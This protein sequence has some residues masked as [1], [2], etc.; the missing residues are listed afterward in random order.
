VPVL[1][2]KRAMAAAIGSRR[3]RSQFSG[4]QWPARDACDK[5]VWSGLWAVS[6]SVLRIKMPR[7]EVSASRRG[8]TFGSSTSLGPNSRIP[9]FF[10]QASLIVLPTPSLPVER[11]VIAPVPRIM[12]LF[13][14][15]SPS[16][17][18]ESPCQEES[19]PASMIDTLE[20]RCRSGGPPAGPRSIDLLPVSK[21][22][23]TASTVA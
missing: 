16:N 21:S 18:P 15:L 8:L 6:S 23:R 14:A 9:P 12:R 19:L 20:A 10:P 13:W 11:G 4:Q 2:P 22:F 5:V 1:R 7:C 3:R 17:S